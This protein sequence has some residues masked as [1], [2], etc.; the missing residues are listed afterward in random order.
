MTLS[1]ICFLLNLIFSLIIEANAQLPNTQLYAGTISNLNSDKWKLDNIQFLSND[2]SDGY[3]NQPFLVDPVTVLFV[4]RKITESNTDIYSCNLN[5]KEKS[6]ITHSKGSEYSPRIYPLQNNVISAV[7]VPEFDSTIQSLV[8]I[9][10]ETGDQSNKF[11][12]HHGKIGYYR[13]LNQKQWVTF[14]VDEPHILAVCDEA[15]D[16][17]NVFASNIGRTMEVIDVNKVLFVHKILDDNWIL[18]EYNVKEGK[19]KIIA[20]MP[21]KTED[22]FRLSNGEI[23]CGSGSKIL[24]WDDVNTNWKEML[25][26]SEYQIN[27]INRI[28]MNQNTLVFVNVVQ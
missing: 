6:R 28:A 2:N 27:N 19:A 8:G 3:N 9:D 23:I 26:F 17:R 4:Q 20:K 13:H 11:L 7:Y 14:I 24:K 25:D 22:F 10:S 12:D 16:T 21:F 18:K 1:K 15:S 5:T